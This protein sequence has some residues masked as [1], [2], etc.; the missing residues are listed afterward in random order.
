[1]SQSRQRVNYAKWS[2][3]LG[4]PI[5]LVAGIATILTVPE[6]VCSITGWNLAACAISQQEIELITQTESGLPLDGVKI[7]VIA[8]GAPENQ[9]TDSNGYATVRI[10][11]R[12]DIR[13]NLSKQDYP[14]QNFTINLENDQS[15]VRIIRFNPSGQP[16]IQ[17]TVTL[18]SLPS[19]SVTPSI[20][21]TPSPQV[22]SPPDSNGSLSSTT[23][24]LE[25]FLFSLQGC[26]WKEEATN[27]TVLITNQQEDRELRLFI[28]QGS[29][30]IDLNGVEY[31]SDEIAFGSE[32][33]SRGYA[34]VTARLAK[35]VPLR[36][37]LTFPKVPSQV[38]KL[39]LL[40][41]SGS[42]SITIQFRDVPVTR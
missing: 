12:G 8:K 19:V 9:Y 22:S 20:A 28:G 3:I 38:N 21:P 29:R 18:P 13:V 35:G 6:S 24:E 32:S 5:A 7:Q 23:T 11:A 27:C 10:P 31:P 40:E 39:A 25:G 30:I 26:L 4:T 17:E 41:I 1:M 2:F 37:V 33:R 34:G 16:E 36:V 14:P 42:D 15:T